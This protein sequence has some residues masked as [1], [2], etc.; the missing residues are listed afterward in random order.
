L[1]PFNIRAQV[2]ISPAGVQRLRQGHLWIYA[3]DVEKEPGGAPP[4]IVGVTDRAHNH[5]GFAFYSKRSQ[6][7][8]RFLTRSADTPTPEWFHERIKATIQRR[9]GLI[10]RGSA[11]RLIF[12]EADLLPSIV[13]DLYSGQVVLQT[14]SSGADALKPFLVESLKSLLAPQGIY[15][16]NDVKARFLEGL[17]EIKGPLWG[18]T[19]PEVEITEE[20]YASM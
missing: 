5:M 12:G 2:M 4:P 6:I 18:S 10:D 13:A 16:R 15:E 1:N 11:C 20:G 7:R 19:P 3:A 14:L 17:D 8:L 9:R